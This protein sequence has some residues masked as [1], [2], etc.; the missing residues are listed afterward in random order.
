MQD[1]FRLAAIEH[2][3]LRIGMGSEFDHLFNRVLLH[4][5]VG[6]VGAT[7]QEVIGRRGATPIHLTISPIV[8]DLGIPPPDFDTWSSKASPSVIARFRPALASASS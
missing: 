3:S 1:V 5:R 8:Y 2:L 4:A 7:G 6:L